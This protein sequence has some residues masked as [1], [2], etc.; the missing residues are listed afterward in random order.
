MK[1]QLLPLA[2]MASSSRYTPLASQPCLVVF[3]NNSVKL[4]DAASM[5]GHFDAPPDSEPRSSCETNRL[6]R[7]PGG[8][9]VLSGEAAARQWPW[10]HACMHVRAFKALEALQF[11]IGSSNRNTWSPVSPSTRYVEPLALKRVTVMNEA[12][13][14]TLGQGRAAPG[15]IPHARPHTRAPAQRY[16]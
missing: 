5:H 15:S 11:G 8:R 7:R 13:V 6:H 4:T 14:E 9:R 2:R 3:Q 16:G 12:P 10:S 1:V